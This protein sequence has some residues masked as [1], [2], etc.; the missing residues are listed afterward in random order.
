MKM[1]RIDMSNSRHRLLLLTVT[2][3]WVA[4]IALAFE[5]GNI[6]LALVLLSPLSLP[7]LAFFANRAHAI[8]NARMER[9]QAAMD[10]GIPKRLAK[11]LGQNDVVVWWGRLH[12]ISTLRWCLL[13]AAATVVTPVLL[14][15]GMPGLV[16]LLGFG[17]MVYSGWKILDIWY[18][19]WVAITTKRVLKVHGVLS[20]DES[21]IDLTSM[22]SLRQSDPWWSK[23]LSRLGLIREFRIIKWDTAVQSE[24]LKIINGVHADEKVKET[25][26]DVRAGVKVEPKIAKA[27]EPKL[28]PAFRRLMEARRARRAV[29]EEP[30]SSPRR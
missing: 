21:A 18:F 16:G 4:T 12:P 13:L 6:K 7:V 30:A 22:T 14:I 11:Y 26:D 15:R 9:M 27:I 20:T 2:C 25:L 10:V 1:P 23:L 19:S 5:A 24:S 29:R 3:L 8:R 17:A 28:R